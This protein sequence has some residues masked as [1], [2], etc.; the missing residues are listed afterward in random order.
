[1]VNPK[2]VAK[3]GRGILLLKVKVD[4]VMRDF[5]DVALRSAGGL[6]AVLEVLQSQLY[7]VIEGLG[8]WRFPI[9][10]NCELA[11]DGDN[12]RRAVHGKGVDLG[13]LGLRIGDVGGVDGFARVGRHFGGGRCVLRKV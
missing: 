12:F 11:G 9:G 6:E 3:D 13:E 7:L 1:M 5:E 4:D 10:L 2:P 8:R